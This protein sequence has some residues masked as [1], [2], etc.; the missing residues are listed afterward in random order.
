MI[1]AVKMYLDNTYRLLN[2]LFF[3]EIILIAS[4]W[5]IQNFKIQMLAGNSLKMCV[6]VGFEISLTLAW[7]RD[8]VPT[9]VSLIAGQ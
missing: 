8:N 1:L 5:Q 4:F 9:L 3:K 6:G 7:D 2:I